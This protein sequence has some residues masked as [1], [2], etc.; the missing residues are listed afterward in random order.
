[1]TDELPSVGTRTGRKSPNVEDRYDH[2]VDEL[3][4]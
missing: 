4:T 3:M 1:V 2:D